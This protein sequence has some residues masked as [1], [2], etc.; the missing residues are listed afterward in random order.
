MHVQSYQRMSSLS[1]FTLQS[2][3]LLLQYALS[4]LSATSQWAALCYKKEPRF[5][6]ACFTLPSCFLKEE[7]TCPQLFAKQT[8]AVSR[9][10]V[11]Q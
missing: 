11:K 1:L 2:T 5:L 4:P 9:R 8:S 10:D 6:L 7:A 3:H